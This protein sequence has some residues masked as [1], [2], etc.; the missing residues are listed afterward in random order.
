MYAL[1]LV[2]SYTFRLTYA[3]TRLIVTLCKNTRSLQKQRNKYTETAIILNR[4]GV[5]D[6]LIPS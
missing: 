5:R 1:L 2:I 3:T 6:V 4:N